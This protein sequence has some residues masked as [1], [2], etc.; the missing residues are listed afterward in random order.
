M[1]RIMSVFLVFLLLCG[2]SK[3][4]VP[5][6]KDTFTLSTTISYEGNEYKAD[7]FASAAD[8][9]KIEFTAPEKL[10]G[11]SFNWDTDSGFI[12]YKKLQYRFTAD[13]APEIFS[14]IKNAFKLI[15]SNTQS[16]ILNTDGTFKVN[17]DGITVELTKDGTPTFITSG[18]VEIKIDTKST[19]E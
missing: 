1:Y 14:S 17:G 15:F 13:D 18:P 11:L 2:C 6:K 4:A 16:A 10:K 5:P 19:E 8:V 3:Q 9:F 7:I 12:E